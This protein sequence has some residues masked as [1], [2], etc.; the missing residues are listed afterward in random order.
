M[1]KKRY[2]L[3]N[4]SEDYVYLVPLDKV[5]A[6]TDAVKDS[7]TTD[8]HIEFK[9]KFSKYIVNPNNLTFTDPQV[10]EKSQAW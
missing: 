7:V 10:Q 1:S 4:C 3:L 6:F 2:K 8:G 5:I 9:R